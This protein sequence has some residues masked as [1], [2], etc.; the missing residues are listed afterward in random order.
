MDQ[1]FYFIK[2]KTNHTAYLFL[3]CPA[4]HRK[5]LRIWKKHPACELLINNIIKKN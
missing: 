4:S 5:E 3:Y 1:S 2:S